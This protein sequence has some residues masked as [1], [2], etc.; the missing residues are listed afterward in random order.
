LRGGKRH[1]PV[2][3]ADNRYLKTQ[4]IPHKRPAFHLCQRMIG[5]LISAV[6]VR[7]CHAKSRIS[8]SDPLRELVRQL[9]QRCQDTYCIV[10][11]TSARHVMLCRDF[12]HTYPTIYSLDSNGEISL[13]EK[14]VSA[15]PNPL[16]IKMPED[17]FCVSWCSNLCS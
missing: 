5:R 17:W 13:F 15:D 8:A 11:Q 6:S 9:P 16:Q 3:S 12:P 10:Y 2:F 7:S 14:N 1:G 4:S